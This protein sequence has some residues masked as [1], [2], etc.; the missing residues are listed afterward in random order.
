MGQIKNEIL[1]RKIAL[2]IKEL[3]KEKNL[4]QAAIFEDTSIHIARIETG[5]NNISVSTLQ[6]I[7]EY[8]EISLSDF[9]YQ[10]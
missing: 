2:Q 6:A 5:K 10:H 4:T 7:C 9:F 1:L 3:R 8:F